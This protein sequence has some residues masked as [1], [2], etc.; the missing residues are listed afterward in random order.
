MILVYTDG[1]EGYKYNG[2]ALQDVTGAGYTYNGVEYEHVYA[3]V[4][5][6]EHDWSKLSTVTKPRGTTIDYSTAVTQAQVLSVYNEKS[7]TKTAVVY[8]ADLNRDKKVDITDVAELLSEE[9]PE[10]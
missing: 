8:R 4:F 7:M 9:L 2:S 1:S 10:E 5:S 3:A 6:G